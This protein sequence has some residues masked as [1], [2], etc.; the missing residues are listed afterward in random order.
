MRT[1]LIIYIATFVDWTLGAATL[2][3]DKKTCNGPSTSFSI[4]HII[5]AAAVFHINDINFLT[6]PFFS[7]A[8]TAF[9]VGNGN[10]LTVLGDPAM[11]PDQI[12]PIDAVL[13][14]HE[15]HPDNLDP[16]GRAHFLDGRKVL[17]TPDGANNLRPRPGVAA[18]QP[19]ETVPL[20][21]GGETWNITGTPCEHL[22]G[23]EVVGFVLRGPG[24]GYTDGLPNA[25]WYTGDTIYLKELAQLRDMYHLRAAVFN[26]G[27]AHADLG[28]GSAPIKVTMN[29]TD[30]ARM[31]KDVGADILVPMH[32]S[33]WSHFW[34]SVEQ[35][36]RDFEEAGVADKVIWLTPGQ[37]TR[38][39]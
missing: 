36:K 28:N 5:T 32:Y 38:I 16:I 2:P 14:S 39:F 18:L 37:R 6:D 12:P 29:G 7:P 30:V 25:I 17:T 22:P 13:L 8:G 11:Q 15:D 9:D 23:G 26:M 27:D 10:V 1:F 3:R 19:W 20:H 21:V 35:V 31:F 4:S 24:F 34:E 33:P